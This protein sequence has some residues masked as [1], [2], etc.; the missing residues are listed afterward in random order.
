M[1][2][3][4]HMGSKQKTSQVILCCN[5]FINH[6]K[7]PIVDTIETVLVGY[8]LGMESG[9]V[10]FALQNAASYTLIYFYA[11]LW[12]EPVEKDMKA[13]CQQME[14]YNQF[15]VLNSYKPLWQCV[16]NLMGRSV[17]PPKLTGE[18]MDEDSFLSESN[19]VNQD[20]KAAMT[21]ISFETCKKERAR[22][23]KAFKH[24]SH[25]RNVIKIM[26]KWVGNGAVNWVHKLLLLNAEYDSL[27]GKENEV[28]NSYDKAIAYVSRAGFL[29]DAALANERAGIFHIGLGDNHWVT[30]YLSRAHSFYTEWGAKAKADHLSNEY[31]SY[32]QVYGRLSYS[33]KSIS[34][35]S[36]EKSL[37]HKKLDLSDS[38]RSTDS[39]DFS[40]ESK[41]L[42][43]LSGSGRSISDISVHRRGSS[44]F[45]D[46][47]AD[48]R[49]MH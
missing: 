39:A 8:N 21:N 32:I 12:L 25:S 40:S 38:A 20:N 31:S 19:I 16:L 26:K 41:R 13:Y 9:E 29:Q 47:R 23:R 18:A 45:S 42:F 5:T 34:R 48:I 24:M 11:G 15:G 6:W 36:S 37:M 2:L 4:D 27:K 7:R 35:F 44:T 3:A 14:E 46:I 22:K 43:Q 10:I 49:T 28:R 1:K 30:H 33:N 17:D